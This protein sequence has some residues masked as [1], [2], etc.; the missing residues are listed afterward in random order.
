M[1][2]RKDRYALSILLGACPSKSHSQTRVVAPQQQGDLH[3]P[4]PT[5][6]PLHQTGAATGQPTGA[7]K[8]NQPS[9]PLRRS[10][11]TR[12]D[13]AE[14]NHESVEMI[15]ICIKE[16]LAPEDHELG[17]NGLR[18]FQSG[19]WVT[20]GVSGGDAATSNLIV[21]GNNVE[22]TG[23]DYQGK[24]FEKVGIGSG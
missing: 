15:A 8:D 20:V 3:A 1:S 7:K 6:D 22:V 4:K 2:V 23:T 10:V 14:D 12:L 18:K 24:C 21:E 16:E 9:S 19:G 13:Y 17:P 5:S 11:R